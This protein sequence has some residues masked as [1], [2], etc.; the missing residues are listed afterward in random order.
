LTM[1]LMVIMSCNNSLRTCVEQGLPAER[2]M[3][4]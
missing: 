3:V 2:T 1:R 4:G